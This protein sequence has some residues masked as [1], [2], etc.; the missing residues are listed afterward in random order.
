MH[1]CSLESQFA[2]LG[3]YRASLVYSLST[4]TVKSLTQ[5][6]YFKDSEVS[7]DI[8]S[9]LVIFKNEGLKLGVHPLFV[10]LYM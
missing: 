5:T 9:G 3:K 1:S 4:E 10:L 2:R 7:M 8:K 6:G